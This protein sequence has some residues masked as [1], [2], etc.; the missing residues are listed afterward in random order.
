MKP[1]RQLILD[2]NIE[3]GRY[4]DCFRT[5]IAILI[6]V[7]AAEVP[8]FVEQAY[9][10]G[11]GNDSSYA[12]RLAKRW[13]NERGY[14]MMSIHL[15][16]DAPHEQFAELTA[17]MPF[18]LTGKSPRYPDICH[19][20]IAQYGPFVIWCPTTAKASQI[21]PWVDAASGESIWSVD[22]IVKRLEALE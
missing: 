17:G 8:H 19:C 1:Q 13:L 10:H 18:M 4:G 2:H 3:A 7:D 11:Y 15:R 20:V 22:I 12:D 5:C 6:E 9:Q 16:G 21:E 14:A